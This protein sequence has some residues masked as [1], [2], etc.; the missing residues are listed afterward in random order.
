MSNKSSR[1]GKCGH[2]EG[3]KSV[4][5]HNRDTFTQTRVMC[6]YVVVVLTFLWWT[7]NLDNA[8]NCVDERGWSSDPLDLFFLQTVS[9]CGSYTTNP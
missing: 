9:A 7:D 2:N 4:V 3:N 6:E 1:T 8:Y 5:V